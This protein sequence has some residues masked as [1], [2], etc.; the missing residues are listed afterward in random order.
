MSL[1]LHD[2]VFSSSLI[3]DVNVVSITLNT[4]NMISGPPFQVPLSWLFVLE[5]NSITY[6]E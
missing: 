6:L 1:T 4:G 3:F 5:V 2:L